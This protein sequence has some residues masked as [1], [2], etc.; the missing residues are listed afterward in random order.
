[1]S[2]MVP[3]VDYYMREGS[4]EIRKYESSLFFYKIVLSILSLLHFHV[5]FRISLSIFVCGV[6]PFI[7]VFNVCNHVQFSSYKC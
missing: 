6:L 5:N 3:V 1:M 2:I 4:F 7:W